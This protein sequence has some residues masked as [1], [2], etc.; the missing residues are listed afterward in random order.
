MKKI[1]VVI[2]ALLLLV[3]G[4][5]WYFVSYRLDGMI[6]QQ[7][8]QV[9][10]ASFGARVSVGSVNTNIKDGSL[11]ISNITVANPPGFKNKEAFSLNGI[12]AAVDYQ[13]M[14]IKRVVIDD[15]DIV[16]EELN[17][18]TNFSMMLAELKSKASNPAPAE[19]GKEQQIIVVHHFRMND[20]RAAFESSSMDHYSNL[21]IDAVELKNVRGTPSEVASAIANEILNE[22]VSEAAKEML[23][24]KAAEKINDSLGKD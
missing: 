7:I 14:N 1:L 17:G 9:G 16:I 15:P 24:A 19:D 20:T 12:E 3:G 23:K 2:V 18:V 11:T 10:S 4:G 8:E 5:V 22:V 13:S 6:E 21:E